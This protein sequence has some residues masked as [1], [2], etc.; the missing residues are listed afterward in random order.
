MKTLRRYHID[1]TYYFI[2]VVTHNRENI[3]LNDISLF[4]Q[5]WKDVK[6]ESWVVL[7]NHFHAIIK[8]KDTNI[9]DIIHNFKIIYSRRYRDKYKSGKVWQNRFW[10]H[11]I[12]NKDD[13]NKHLDYIHYNPVKHG[14]INDPFLYKHSS[15]SLHYDKGVYERNW[16]VTK[17]I[18]I[19]G[20]Y[21]E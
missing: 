1:N 11:I 14:L 9:S 12:R 17:K 7:P 6:L 19:K 18:D 10:D 3:L 8:I 2:T 16:G 21:G 5:S 20:E 13:M 4:W 15:L